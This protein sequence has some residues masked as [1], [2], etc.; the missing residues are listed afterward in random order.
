M[1]VCGVVLYSLPTTIGEITAGLRIHARTLQMMRPSQM[2]LKV[3]AQHRSTPTT[4]RSQL[5]KYAGGALLIGMARASS[6]LHDIMQ[7]V[8]CFWA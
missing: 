1:R 5:T 6:V 4:L 7:D 8:E 3:S 2:P